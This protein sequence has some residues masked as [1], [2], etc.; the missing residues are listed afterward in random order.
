MSRNLVILSFATAT[1]ALGTLDWANAQT[2]PTVG[3]M[4]DIPI[5]GKSASDMVEGEVRKID[6]DAK[7]ITLKHAEI[8]NLEMASMTMVFQVKD[9][10]ML[11]A[12]KVGDRVRFQAQKVGGAIVITE[13]QPVK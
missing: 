5:A 2:T 11:D 9:M 7:K 13:L 1:V 3:T 10:A 6:K 4:Q 12:V 8:P